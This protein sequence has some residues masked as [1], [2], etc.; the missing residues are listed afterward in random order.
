[1]TRLFF[2]FFVFIGSFV[3]AQKKYHF[4][5]ALLY[6]NYESVD[7]IVRSEL[8]FVN[9]NDNSFVMHTADNKDSINANIS[10]IDYKGL[11]VISKTKK[12]LFYQAETLKNECNSVYKFSN[13][14]KNKTKEYTFK[15]HNDTVIDN[16][17]YYHYSLNS[18]K[19]KKYQK[20]KKIKS[21]HLIFDSSNQSILPF[22]PFPLIYNLYIANP[23]LP[24]GV[25]IIMYYVDVNGQITFKRE[26][27][28]LI[29]TD[30]YLSV[31][32]E[33]DYTKFPK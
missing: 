19:S 32:E 25:P 1:M 33:C 30:K 7:K 22:L 24:K 6:K 23:I 28:E 5:Y 21:F 27:V 18:L 14:H 17:N 2:L 11:S 26:L 12:S 29:K 20:R 3:N 10:L 15:K 9:S 13:L 4:D 16:K 8:Y 31:P